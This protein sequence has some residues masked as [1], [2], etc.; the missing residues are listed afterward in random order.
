MLVEFSWEGESAL[1]PKMYTFLPKCH[2][3]SISFPDTDK[4]SM[5]LSKR[6][7]S[8]PALI[9]K[10]RS[11]TQQ[12]NC[13]FASKEFI[14]P[15]YFKVP[16]SH[17]FFISLLLFL[18]FFKRNQFFF[19]FFWLKFHPENLSLTHLFSFPDM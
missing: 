11:K 9:I 17:F 4:R 2:S 13:N 6:Q 19:F 7:L 15:F 5:F 8:A 3:P 18:N 1:R 16:G 10:A 14:I 12:R